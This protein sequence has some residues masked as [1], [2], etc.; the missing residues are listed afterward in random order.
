M[1]VSVSHHNVIAE[2]DRLLLQ[3][4]GVFNLAAYALEELIP[5]VSLKKVAYSIGWLC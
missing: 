1:R 5:P 3:L 2:H 4:R